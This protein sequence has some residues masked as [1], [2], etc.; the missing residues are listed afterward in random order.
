MKRDKTF[1]AAVLANLGNDL[2][3]FD[4]IL[5]PE[6]G[7]SQVLVKIEYAGLCHSQL[8]EVQGL[9]GEDKY[10]PHMLGHEGVGSV[11]SVGNSVTKVV[12]GDAVILSWIKGDGQDAG[13]YQYSSVRGE[14]INAGSVTTFS[15]YAIVAENRLVKMPVGT[16][17][18]LAVL[19]GCAVPTGF[20]MVMNNLP[21]NAT[22]SIAFIGLGGIG[23]SALLAA[24]MYNFKNVFAIDINDDKLE[25]A[26]KYGATRVINPSRENPL[27]VI[28]DITHG[29]GVDYSFESAG[30]AKTIEMAYSFVKSKGGLCTFASHPSHAEKISLDPFDLICG[31]N[32]KGT[33]GGEVYPDRD[34]ERFN[35]LYIQGDLPLET[36]VSKEYALDEINNAIDDLLNRKIV[37][38]LIRCGSELSKENFDLTKQGETVV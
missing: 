23:M 4:D 15:E 31:K 22:G 30:T 8:M 11:V 38:A 25:I 13:G 3:I 34:I 21:E 17:S 2:E 7:D 18:K 19:Y 16:P 32:I 33:W 28:K 26:K 12:P 36:L 35:Q 6:P 27:D 20:G 37:R 5:L 24:G 14:K 9:R 10:L 29:Q 1:R